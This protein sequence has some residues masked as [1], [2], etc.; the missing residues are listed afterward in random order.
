MT[1]TDPTAIYLDALKV[2]LRHGPLK[3]YDTLPL[4]AA[5]EALR[6]RVADLEN[7]NIDAYEKFQLE[8]AKVIAAEARLAV[9]LAKGPGE[10][11]G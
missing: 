7:A 3:T 11:D 10:A 8:A 5:V 9:G 1:T 6:V 4:I 2:K